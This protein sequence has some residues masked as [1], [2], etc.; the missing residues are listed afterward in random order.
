M[1]CHIREHSLIWR[2]E[3]YTTWHCVV[4]WLVPKILKYHYAL[5]STIQQPRKTYWTAWPLTVRAPQSFKLL[6]TIHQMPPHP[7]RLKILSH[8]SVRSSN[9]TSFN[10]PSEPYTCWQSRSITFLIHFTCHPSSKMCSRSSHIPSSKF[11]QQARTILYK[12]QVGDPPI[13]KRCLHGLLIC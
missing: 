5:I 8:A 1:T 9:L 6:G 11:N 12:I 2:F 13:R 4:W 3:S 10:L 7:R